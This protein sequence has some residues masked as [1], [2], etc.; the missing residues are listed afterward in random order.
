MALEKFDNYYIYSDGKILN[1]KLNIFIKLYNNRLG[2]LAI[3]LRNNDKK[4]KQFY[5]HRL[6]AMLY[7]ENNNNCSD[8]NHKDCDKSNNNVTNLECVT[9]SANLKHAFINER[10]SG[11]LNVIIG[12][13]K[14]T[15]LNNL[16]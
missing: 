5:A 8:V 11:T 1:L 4:R 13:H 9:H 16:V 3:K 14:L 12:Y 15:H 7:L 2:Y 6:V 10:L